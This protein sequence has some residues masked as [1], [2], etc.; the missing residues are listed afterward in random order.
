MFQVPDPPPKSQLRRSKLKDYIPDEHD[1]ELHQWLMDWRQKTSEEEYGL[2]FV[3]HFGCS[4][5]MTD[6]VLSR[7]CDAA[8]QHLITSTND[9]YKESRWH[10]TQK[11]G[12]MVV[13]KIKETI[14]AAPPPSKPTTVRKCS[15]CRQPGHDSELL[16]MLLAL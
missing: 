6:Q 10:L 1:K 14:P 2:P 3:K 9:L 7:I 11:Y 5:I 15:K 4:N 16:K 8:H 12:Q 13:D